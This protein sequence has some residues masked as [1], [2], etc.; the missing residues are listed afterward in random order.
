MARGGRG[1]GRRGEQP[2]EPTTA[3]IAGRHPAGGT[4]E[5]ARRRMEQGRGTKGAK[6]PEGSRL[7][8]SRSNLKSPEPPP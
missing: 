6:R 8:R 2:N 7:R 4:T 3:G 1:H 5:R